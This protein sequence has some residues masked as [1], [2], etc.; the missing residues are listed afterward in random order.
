VANSTDNVY[1]NII[2]NTQS[3][4]KNMADLAK[5]VFGAYL[6]WKTFKEIIVGSLK[7]FMGAEDAEKRLSAAIRI[8]GQ[9]ATASTRSLVRYAEGLQSVTNYTHEAS[10]EAMGVLM[11]LGNLTEE[12]VKKA[13]PALQDFAAFWQMDLVQAAELFGKTLASDTNAMARYGVQ[14]A[15]GLGPQEKLVSIL[16][17]LEK[18]MGGFAEEMAT[19]TSGK[20][21][22]FQIQIDELKEGF[23]GLLASIATS[24]WGAQ[25]V[26][27]VTT[28]LDVLNWKISGYKVLL[29]DTTKMTKQELVDYNT[30]LNNQKKLFEGIAAEAK[31]KGILRIDE[32]E[33]AI[34]EIGRISSKMADVNRQLQT[35]R[36][37]AGGA[38]PS[39]APTLVTG[40]GGPTPEEIL[41]KR[42]KDAQGWLSDEQKAYNQDLENGAVSMDSYNAAMYI[43]EQRALAAAEAQEKLDASIGKMRT[44]MEAETQVSNPSWANEDQE[45]MAEAIADAA[46][47][48]ADAAV[49]AADEAERLKKAKV[50]EAW[51][52]LAEDFKDIAAAMA[53]EAILSFFDSMGEVASGTKTMGEALR[54]MISQL[55]ASLGRM[56]VAAGLELIIANAYNPALVATGL[57]LIAAGGVAIVAGAVAGSKGDGGTDIPRMAAGGV[58][59]RPTLALIGE[60]GPEAV[61]PLGRG[62]GGTTIIVQGSIWQTEDLA[63]AVA[64]AQARW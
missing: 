32:Y 3:A 64:G 59:T 8:T 24:D 39:G 17:Q 13:L 52:G 19:T 26:G 31:G 60:A 56:M 16:G 22:A 42:L 2:A 21:K 27:H 46:R 58:V 48:A 11:Q 9:Q 4:M 53:S 23:G 28:L 18:G 54:E 47:A 40:G 45:A 25:A 5:N 1:V 34:E 41:A 6:S 55:A 15:K 33:K 30:E 57:A 35:G 7:E 49:R 63:R 10:E 43:L 14:L 44:L 12:G 38:K 50:E 62:A 36:Y 20:L 29:V 37:A 51:K 61:V